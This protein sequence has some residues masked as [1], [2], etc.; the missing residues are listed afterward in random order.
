MQVER[1]VI[2][3][4]ATGAGGSIRLGETDYPVGQ[5][6]DRDHAMLAAELPKI[7]GRQRQNRLFSLTRAM[8]SFAAAREFLDATDPPPVFDGEDKDQVARSLQRVILTADGC[9]YLAWLLIRKQQPAITLES[10][11]PLITEDNASA[12]AIELMAECGMMA[13]GPNSPGGPGSRPGP[14]TSAA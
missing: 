8:G 6:T 9:R 4:L 10:L 1:S 14:P 5:P 13:I 2:N 7:A 12:V 11:R 3:H